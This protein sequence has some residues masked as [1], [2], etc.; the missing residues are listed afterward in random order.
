[1]VLVEKS[2]IN[3]MRMGYLEK[4]VPG[5]RFIHI[6]RDGIDVA[7]SIEKLAKVTRR[8]AFSAPL[9][10]WWGVGDAKWESMAVDG[11]NLGYYRDEVHSLT[12]D[13]ERG[14]YEWL[15][16]LREVDTWRA[17]LGSRLIEVRYQDLTEHPKE[18]LATIARSIELSCPPG[19]LDEASAEVEPARRNDGG[20]LVLPSAM[21]ADFNRW[22]ERFGFPGRAVS[23]LLSSSPAARDV[24]L[25]ERH[26]MEESKYTEGD[27]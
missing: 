18:V 22:Q 2:P 23:S 16:S 11:Q 21:C 15:L 20:T 12:A 4:L 8:M 17:K 10:D 26:S 27:Y 1:M 14:A 13:A 9:N 5:A 7:R 3:A 6:V 24:L 25:C 19:W